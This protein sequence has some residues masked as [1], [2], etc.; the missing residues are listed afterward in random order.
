MFLQYL[1]KFPKNS[2]RKL[3]LSDNFEN[4]GDQTLKGFNVEIYRDDILMI[5]PG[6]YLELTYF[7]PWSENQGLFIDIPKNHP[8]APVF[9]TSELSGCFVG[10]QD[11]G[12]DYR[13]RHYNFQSENINPDDFLVYHD[14]E[15]PVKWLVPNRGNVVAVMQSNGIQIEI[16][17]NYNAHNPVVLWGEH[18][19]NDWVFYYQ[20]SDKVIHQMQVM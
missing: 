16:Y 8:Q 5:F 20:T 3:R 7:L 15:H 14:D 13:I 10:I 18:I 2:L 17:E 12:T 4:I 11:L 6:D 9:L 19:N 1:S